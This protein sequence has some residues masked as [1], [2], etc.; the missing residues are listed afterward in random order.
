MTASKGAFAHTPSLNQ[1]KIADGLGLTKTKGQVQNT[2]SG[3]A[4]QTFETFL[5]VIQE[6]PWEHLND[7]MDQVET[8]SLVR[9]IGNSWGAWDVKKDVARFFCK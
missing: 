4:Q 6:L 5:E 8:F 2:D 7:P 9:A 3:V 1:I